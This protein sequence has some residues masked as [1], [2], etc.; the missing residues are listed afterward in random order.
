MHAV[1][2]ILAALV[3]RGDDRRGRLP[4]RVGRRRR[5]RAHVAARRRVPRHRRGAR[6]RPRHPHRPLRLLRRLPTAPTASGSR[7]RAIEPHFW[8]N[9]C[10]AL[11][12]RAVGRAPDRRRGAG[13]D[14]RRLRAPRSRTRTATTGSRELGAGRHVRRRRSLSVPELVDDAQFAR[15]RRVRRR[16]RTPSHGDVPSRS[17]GCSR[18]WTA[19]QPGPYDVRDATVTD[20]D[21]L[22][23][24]AGYSRRR[25]RARCA[26][27]EWSRDA[28]TTT[29]CP[30]TSRR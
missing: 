22:L 12:L 23:R 14:P 18:A 5:A 9:L 4:R 10:R 30:P 19:R 15:A 3:R 25:D 13:R 1:M 11:G 24:A 21:E 26:T 27:K 28:I 29:S 7:S 20:T 17:A 2:A 8:A 16:R 6:A